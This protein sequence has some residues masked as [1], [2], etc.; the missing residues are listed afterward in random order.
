MES[1]C[2]FGEYLG[3]P[4]NAAPRSSMQAAFAESSPWRTVGIDAELPLTKGS[5]RP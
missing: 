3:S 2:D 4:K 1:R 5:N